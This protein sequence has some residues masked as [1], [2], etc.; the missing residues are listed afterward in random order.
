MNRIRMFIGFMM[1]NEI[2]QTVARIARDTPCQSEIWLLCRM[3]PF[4]CMIERDNESSMFLH[5]AVAA[6]ECM[7]A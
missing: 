5:H 6:E 1:F 4:Y 2:L 7:D 3:Q